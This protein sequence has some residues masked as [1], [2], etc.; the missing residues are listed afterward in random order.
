MLEFSAGV[1]EYRSLK[2]GAIIQN[3]T[4]AYQRVSSKPLEAPRLSYVSSS[5]LGVELV[6]VDIVQ[7]ECGW[8]GGNIGHETGV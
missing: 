3:V 7:G 6:D 5:R 4:Q 8:V 1:L 2:L